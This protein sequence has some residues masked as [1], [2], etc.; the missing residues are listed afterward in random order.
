MK[1]AILVLLV[2]MMSLCLMPSVSAG[3]GR[4]YVAPQGTPHVDGLV[5]D[6]WAKAPWTNIDKPYD[7]VDNSNSVVRIKL[8]WDDE[9]LYFLA[10]IYDSDLHIDEDIVE[11]YL[12]Q[13]HNKSASFLEDDSQTRFRVSGTIVTGVHSG[14][15]AQVDCPFAVEAGEEEDTYIMEGQFYWTDIIPEVGQTMGIEFMYNDAT[16]KDGFVEAYRWNVKQPEDPAPFQSTEGFGTLIFGDAD[17]KA[18]ETTPGATETPEEI[19]TPEEVTTPEETTTPEEVT[20]PEETTTPAE[21][22]KPADTTDAKDTTKA[23]AD[24]KSS[25]GLIVG[26][27]AAVVVVAVVVVVVLKKKRA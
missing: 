15:N 25:V 18:P 19:T 27:V 1:K 20:T 8:M 2:L 22:T 12:D 23:P 21:T 9:Y 24:D 13:R 10:E 7:Q 6:L 17:G 11:I 26:I 5:D 4:S 16:A 14:P 3:Y